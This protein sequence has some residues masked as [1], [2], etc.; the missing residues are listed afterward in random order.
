MIYFRNIKLYVSSAILFSPI[1][2]HC[3]SDFPMDMLAL[4]YSL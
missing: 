1:P 3:I 4:V 2:R